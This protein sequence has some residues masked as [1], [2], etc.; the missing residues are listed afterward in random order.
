MLPIFHLNI[1]QHYSRIISH[2]M[3][4]LESKPKFE[5]DHSFT[6]SFDCFDQSLTLTFNP[7]GNIGEADEILKNVENV[8]Y[9]VNFKIV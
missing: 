5:K 9:F 4:K 6:L 7:S 3:L 1:A 2:F 8:F